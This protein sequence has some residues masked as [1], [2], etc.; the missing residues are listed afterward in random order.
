M[1]YNFT[2]D[3]D[4]RGPLAS[5]VF[6]GSGNLYGTTYLGGG[7]PCVYGC[8]VVFKL[9]PSSGG[10][11]TE[12]VPHSFAGGKAGRMPL[13][14]V[15]FDRAGNLYGTTFVGGGG[16]ALC[17]YSPDNAHGCG[18]VFML[19][20]TSS[21]WDYTVLKTFND[22]SGA[23]PQA[24]L[25]SDSVGNFYGTTAGDGSTTFGTVYEITP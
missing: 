12:T 6:D 1:L 15:V 14:P 4:G 8:G 24:G 16:G 25:V 9:A 17:Y 2:G 11:W 3:K 21:G 13:A 7:G 22:K 19:T 23:M 10:G 5:L 20:P 18:V